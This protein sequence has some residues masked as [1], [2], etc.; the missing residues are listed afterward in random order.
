MIPH[1][2]VYNEVISPIP[3]AQRGITDAEKAHACDAV[4]IR[5][6][7]RAIFMKVEAGECDR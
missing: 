7:E 3:S 5:R 1:R 6:K 2:S 4:H